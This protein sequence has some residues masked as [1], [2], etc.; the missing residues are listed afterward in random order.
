MTIIRAKQNGLQIYYESLLSL[1]NFPSPGSRPSP[2]LAIMGGL[3]LA[4]LQLQNE[5]SAPAIGSLSQAH[6][7]TE[8]A[9]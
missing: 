2:R 3:F 5:P 9:N 7:L 1:L 4:V 6:S 8:P